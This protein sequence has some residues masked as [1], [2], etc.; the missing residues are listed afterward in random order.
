MEALSE[1]NMD[2]VDAINAAVA[3]LELT[4]INAYDGGNLFIF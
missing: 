1:G 3:Q 4:R 2:V